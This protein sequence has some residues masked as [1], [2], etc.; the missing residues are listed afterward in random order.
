MKKVEVFDPA[1]CCSLAIDPEELRF[2]ALV[3]TLEEKGIEV[4]RYNLSREPQAYMENNVIISLL[5]KEGVDALPATLV[6]GALIKTKE[7]PSNGEMSE[8]LGIT[9]PTNIR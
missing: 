7:Y 2:T 6:D 1:T 9:L 4:V 3:K 5:E 8:L